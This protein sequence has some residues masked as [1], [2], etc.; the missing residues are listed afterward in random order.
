MNLGYIPRKN[1]IVWISSF[2]PLYFGFISEFQEAEFRVSACYICLPTCEVCECVIWRVVFLTLLQLSLR[3]FV[4]Q[5]IKSSCWPKSQ[6]EGDVRVC[7]DAVFRCIWCGFGVTF[8]LTRGIAVSKHWAVCGY[9][10]LQ[11]AV[12][13]EK[14]CLRWWHSLERSA[15]GGLHMTSNG[16]TLTKCPAGLLLSE[17]FKDPSYHP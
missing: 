5:A 7:G 13:G 6:I 2:T 17:I 15:S 8:I 4:L 11:V 3:S 9:Y 12:F 14:E 10:N 1:T 16:S